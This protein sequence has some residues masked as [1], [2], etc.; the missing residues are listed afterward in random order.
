MT[1]KKNT[2]IIITLI[3]IYTIIQVALFKLHNAT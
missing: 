1:I 3:V 2:T